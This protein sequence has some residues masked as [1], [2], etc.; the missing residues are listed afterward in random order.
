MIHMT[1]LSDPGEF[2]S[3]YHSFGYHS[4]D[5][6]DEV[7]EAAI[8]LLAIS[9]GYWIESRAATGL[10]KRTIGTIRD[11]YNQEVEFHKLFKQLHKRA[12]GDDPGVQE[13]KDMLL[14]IVGGM[15][16][17]FWEDEDT[18]G[19][20]PGYGSLSQIHTLITNF[21]ETFLRARI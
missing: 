2:K 14:M 5:K 12:S 1:L 6:E 15:K 3:Y 18:W 13:A 7:N 21:F 17:L 8:K 20:I 10:D 11:T 19:K 4:A 16:R 9:V